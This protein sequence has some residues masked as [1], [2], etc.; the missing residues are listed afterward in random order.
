MDIDRLLKQH[1]SLLA[2]VEEG[3]KGRSGSAR[4]AERPIEVRLARA[5]AIKARIGA[6]EDARRE[7]LNSSDAQI[8]AL[9]SELADVERSLGRDRE[10]LAP[11][12]KA[13]GPKREGSK[14]TRNVAGQ[15]RSGRSTATTRRARR[16]ESP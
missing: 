4:A 5:E 1:D 14:A 15:A 3:L 13:A 11:A 9:R 7:F 16:S 6:C 8:L 10:M 12:A 2:E